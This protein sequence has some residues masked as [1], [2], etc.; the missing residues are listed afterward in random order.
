VVERASRVGADGDALSELLRELPTCPAATAART[1]LNGF[2]VGADPDR[3]VLVVGHLRLTVPA[4]AVIDIEFLE[5][6]AEPV[7][8]PSVRTTLTL[9]LTL[10][11]ASESLPEDILI[12]SGRPFVVATRPRPVDYQ[13]P[14]GYRAR[15]RAFLDARGIRTPDQ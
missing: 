7:M 9:P 1:V 3:I 12:P 13:H 2:L 15:E 6:D 8:T 11:D 5:P 10:L 4:E 14:A